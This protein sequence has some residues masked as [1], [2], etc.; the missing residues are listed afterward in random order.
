M[1]KLKRILCALLSAL[2]LAA[3]A[4]SAVFSAG[5]E[6]I[7]SLQSQLNELERKNNEYQAILDKTEKNI[8]EKEE[9]NEA[10]VNKITTLNEKINVTRQSIEALEK[11][12]SENQKTLDASNQ[13]IEEQVD[14]LCDRLRVIYM[15][16]SASDLE[17]VLGAKDFSDFIDKMNLVKTLSGYDKELIADVKSKVE[18]ITKQTKQLEADREDLK[19]KED[20][21]NEDLAELNKL[22]DENKESL[23]NLYNTSDSAKQAMASVTSD[24]ANIEAEIAK[25]Y[26][27]QEKARKAAED[28][29]KKASSNTKKSDSSSSSSSNN[30]NDSSSGDNDSG[31]GSDSSGSQTAPVVIPDSSHV[32]PPTGSGYTWPCPGFYYLSSEWNE[33]RYTY[34]HGAIDIAGA[35]ILGA[36]VVAADSGT[37][38]Y[39]CTYCIHNWG[40]SGSCGCGGGY[41]NYVWINHGNGK[42]TIYAHLTSVVV[43]PGDYVSK[44]EIVGYVGSTGYSTGPH[45]HFECRYNGVKYN[46]MTEF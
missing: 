38:S 18:D 26:E 14:A 28:A 41:G 19:S 37:V 44:G 33:Y 12:I 2:I 39:T 4:S 35:G 31:S 16:G 24:A 32:T 34:N 17:I 3:P 46:P 29:A 36:A 11:S 15:A 43:S 1:K 5:A 7:D 20:S 13:E 23:M 30:D 10:L 40:K 27:E 6:S 22:L 25:Y 8:Q 21:L 9:Y 42:E 45:L